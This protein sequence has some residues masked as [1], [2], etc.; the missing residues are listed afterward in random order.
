MLKIMIYKYKAVIPGNKVFIREYELKSEMN[1]FNFNSFL[2][3]D[4]GFAP[5]QIVAFR[6][7][8]AS[9]VFHSE[10]GLFDLGD[11]SM[12]MMTFEKLY[13]KGETEI[14]YVFDMFKE[15]YLCLFYDGEADFSPKLSYPRTITEKG[16]NPDQFSPNYEEDGDSV[17]DL[18]IAV[19]EVI[20]E[21]EYDDSEQV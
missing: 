4:L 19:E 21:S 6:G 9:G 12:D 3:N 5:D 15:R 20:D 1:L 13:K 8:D 11:G 17:V 2:L 7:Y 16:R 18:N 10:Y 14:H